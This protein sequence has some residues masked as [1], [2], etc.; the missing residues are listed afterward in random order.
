MDLTRKY[1][2]AESVD[3]MA[4]EG[5]WTQLRK[6]KA[7]YPNV[8]IIISLGGWT[9]SKYFS[10]AASTPVSRDRL[11]SSCVNLFLLGRG[12][13]VFDGIDIDWEF[14]GGGGMDGNAVSPMDKTNFVLL[15]QNFKRRLPS[16]S[17]LTIAVGAGPDKI[18]NL[19]VNAIS[20]VVDW[21]N[22]MSY[23]YH[24]SWN[25]R[26]PTAHQSNM[27]ADGADP[28][29]NTIAFK[30]NTKEAVSSLIAAGAT[31]EKVVVGVPFYARGWAGVSKGTSQWPGLYQ[32]AARPVTGES[33]PFKNV[34]A[35]PGK[36][37]LHTPTYQSYKYD[38]ASG[39]FWTY[40]SAETMRYKMQWIK[41][42][43]LGGVFAWSVDGDDGSLASTFSRL[44]TA[45]T[46]APQITHVTVTI[47]KTQPKTKTVK[48]TAI[49]AI[50]LPGDYQPTELPPVP[51]SK[52]PSE[53][54]SELLSESQGE[55]DASF[56]VTDDRIPQGNFGQ[57]RPLG[58]VPTSTTPFEE[59]EEVETMT[60]VPV[61]KTMSV[62]D[63]LRDDAFIK[64][65]HLEDGFK[66]YG[67]M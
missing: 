56:D 45:N 51:T 3:G 23:D 2:P 40:D 20:E 64:V 33:I 5:T 16:G 63:L 60:Q 27:F 24:G 11:A 25:A 66:L 34:A 7:Q 9:W 19:Q 52:L 58:L 13:G 55:A 65:Q 6:L 26:G 57:A 50:T 54:E 41:Q 29:R 36:V 17:L 8:K 61:Q 53:S 38:E 39:T 35:Q 37:Y 30:Y 28:Y 1:S 49:Q 47:T 18:G 31:R 42:E 43:R 32:P 14:P 59:S 46:S 67:A 4:S 15:L 10:A 21:I 62:D 44:F 22:V 48:T 12:K